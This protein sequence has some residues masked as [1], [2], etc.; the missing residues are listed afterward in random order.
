METLGSSALI[1][2]SEWPF[3][4]GYPWTFSLASMQSMLASIM[5]SIILHVIVLCLLYM[6]LLP[7]WLEA[8]LIVVKFISQF[9]IP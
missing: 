7:F 8:W 2:I 5:T 1:Y 9:L 3:I 4:D 6:A